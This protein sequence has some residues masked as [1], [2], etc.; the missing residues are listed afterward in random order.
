MCYLN[1]AGQSTLPDGLAAPG[2]MYEDLLLSWRPAVATTPDDKR[3][4]LPSDNSS[5]LEPHT[6]SVACEK[7]SD[8]INHKYERLV[9]RDL[10]TV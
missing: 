2:L 1:D 10:V 9:C 8:C 4:L 5:I 7:F 3:D 6:L